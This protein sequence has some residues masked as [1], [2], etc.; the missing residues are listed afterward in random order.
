ME[1]P[2]P[3]IECPVEETKYQQTVEEMK[4]L[5]PNLKEEMK[6]CPT[7]DLVFTLIET[8]DFYTLKRF[9]KLKSDSS[10]SNN[11]SL[12]QFKETL[13]TNIS[14]FDSFV[15]IPKKNSFALDAANNKGNEFKSPKVYNIEGDESVIDFGSGDSI[16]FLYDNV[17]DLNLF[18]EKNKNM[19][20]A[21]FCL[22]INVN[23]F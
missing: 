12:S 19:K 23:F 10:S 7:T 14:S 5:I 6:A 15:V 17:S 1:E 9:F 21:C 2:R 11:K 16:V 3:T 18:L 13:L 8:V 4:T 22:G 20:M